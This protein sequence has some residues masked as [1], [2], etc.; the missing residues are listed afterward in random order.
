[1]TEDMVAGLGVD[2]V[3]I[4]RFQQALIR[5]P[6]ITE[7]V[8]TTAERRYCNR[9]AKPSIHYA[10]RFAAKEAIWKVLGGFTGMTFHDVEVMR[11]DHGRPRAVLHGHAL[12]RA[13]ELGIIEFH[14]SLSFTHTTAVASAVALTEAARPRKE[15]DHDPRAELARSFKELRGMLDEQMGA[16]PVEEAVEEHVQVIDDGADS[17]A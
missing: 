10:L 5:T 17:R 2:I 4:E 9:K 15:D 14:L 13:D 11:D 3:D 6:R 16:V 1:M 8:F 12:E 7:R